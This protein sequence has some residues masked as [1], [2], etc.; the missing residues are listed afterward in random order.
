MWAKSRPMRTLPLHL[1]FT[2]LCITALA[3][4]AAAGAQSPSDAQI[5]LV[6]AHLADGAKKGG[7]AVL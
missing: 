6:H 1:F 5:S 4:P 3:W 2:L 7:Q